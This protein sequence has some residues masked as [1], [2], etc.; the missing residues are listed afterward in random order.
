MLLAATPCAAQEEEPAPEE[1]TTSSSGSGRKKKAADEGENWKDPE[2]KKKAEGLSFCEHDNCYELLGVQPTSGPIPI[3]RAYRRL[4]AE[5]HPDKCPSGDIAMC[6]A[7][8]PKYANAYE[9]L[10]SGEMRKNYDY[11]LANP[12]EFPGFYMKYSRPKYAPKSDL[13]FVFLVT[14]LGASAMQYL[15]RKS[16]HEQAFSAMKRAPTTRYQ[17][18]VKEAMATLQKS[19][20]KAEA[21]APAPAPAPA[22]GAKAPP[23]P[24]KAKKLSKQEQ[25]E[26][27]RKEAE[28]V[29]DAELL[30]LLGPAPTPYDSLAASLFKLPLTSLATAQWYMAGGHKEPAYM[31]RKALGMS[32]G[33]WDECAEAEQE[34]L[35]GKELW[36]SANLTAYEEEVAKSTAKPKSGKQK[37]AERQAKKNPGAVMMDD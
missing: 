28:G 33:E 34:E 26:A 32:Q 10:S 21:A 16:Q 19:K 31:T 29:V 1:E 11:V 2:R 13:R 22:D 23:S 18:R 5:Y 6:R 4:A 35:V 36:I 8:F 7:E 25:L 27:T 3:K 17:E 15:L 37:R 14:V 12:F 24:S 9:I 30:E 20:P